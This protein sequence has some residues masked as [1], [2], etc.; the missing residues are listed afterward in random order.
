MSVSSE[1]LAEYVELV[2][3]IVIRGLANMRLTTIDI[4]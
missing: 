3:E 4:S 1:S 2:M